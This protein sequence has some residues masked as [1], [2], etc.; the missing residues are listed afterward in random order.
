[1]SKDEGSF[2]ATFIEV[3]DVT[4]VN[5]MTSEGEITCL[6]ETDLVNLIEEDARMQGKTFDEMV[7][8]LLRISFGLPSGDDE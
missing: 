7:N 6:M 5:M 1:M 2:D 4:P 3:L 8:E